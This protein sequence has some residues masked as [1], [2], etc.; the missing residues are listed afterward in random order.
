MQ[1]LDQSLAALVLQGVVTYE[2][3]LDRARDVEAFDR[4]CGRGRRA[5]VGGYAGVR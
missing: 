4:L 2:T 3:A 1:T 5:P